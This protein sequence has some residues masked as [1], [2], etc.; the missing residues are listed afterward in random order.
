MAQTMTLENTFVN[1]GL[2]GLT[3]DQLDSLF[4]QGS[5]PQFEQVKGAYN[6]QVLSGIFFPLSIAQGVQLTN[7]G[8]LPWK[9][10]VFTPQNQ[11]NGDGLN[12]LE[13]GLLKNKMFYF[14]SMISDSIYDGKPVYTLDYD[15]PGNPWWLCQVRDEMKALEDGTLLGRA[16]F[17]FQGSHKFLL[18]FSLN[19]A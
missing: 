18:Y 4:E 10:K 3:E 2:L 8:W 17:K 13:V 11:T 9:G 14:K 12:R 1:K 6:G 19:K 15:Q 5:T 16:Y 7:A